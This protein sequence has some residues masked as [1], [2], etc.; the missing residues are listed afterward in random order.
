MLA[1]LKG[2]PMATAPLQPTL[3]LLLVMAALTLLHCDTGDE[4][5]MGPDGAGTPDSD[6]PDA[7]ATPDADTTSD[8]APAPVCVQGMGPMPR[9]LLLP[10]GEVNGVFDPNLARDPAT[11]RLWM[12]YSGVTGPAGSGKVST[13]LSYS[14]DQGQT[15]C[16]Q[17]VVNAALVVPENEQPVGIAKPS[18]HW[19]EE[20]S[21][22]VYDPSAPS[23]SRWTLIWMKYLHIE[24]NIPGNEDRHFEHGWIAQ[25]KAATAEGLLAAPETKLFSASLYHASAAIEEYNASV[26]GGLPE[27]SWA[28]DADLG[29]CLAFAEPG[30]IA[31][32]SKVYVAMYCARDEV[33]RDVVLVERSGGVWSYKGTLLTAAHA[34]AIHPALTSF[35]GADLVEVDGSIHLIVSPT[36]GDAYLGCLDYEVNTAT[37]SLVDTDDNGPDALYAY[38]ASSDPDVYL[39]GAC[40]YDEDSAMGLVFGEVHATGTQFRLFATGEKL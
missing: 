15:W 38:P 5:S 2:D 21:A 3:R 39:S 8:A 9:E 36:A 32:D 13:H 40:T 19:N 25:R 17:G 33:N 10:N 23:E 31:V 30:I 18:A 20:T 26:P 14:D 16:H 12:S 27:K 28:L 24:D 37:G 35:N 29:S 6:M 22:I 11:Q 7:G 34:S 4:S 1:P